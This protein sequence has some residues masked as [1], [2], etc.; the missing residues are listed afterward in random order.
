M[1]ERLDPV[2]FE[3]RR[4]ELTTTH[5]PISLKDL[6]AWPQ[7]IRQAYA[8]LPYLTNSRIVTSDSPVAL[9]RVRYTLHNM[10][11]P[12]EAVAA[13]LV[14]VWEDD[15]AEGLHEVTHALAIGPVLSFSFLALTA[16]KC[17][18]TGSL[19]VERE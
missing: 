19:V 1:S 14:K 9:V 2:A 7:D 17:Y 3:R 13:D 16:E 4:R 12:F 10:V 8:V 11:Q 5:S 15:L 18:V 6:E